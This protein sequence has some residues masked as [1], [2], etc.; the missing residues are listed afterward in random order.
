M[1]HNET[2]LGFEL[3][4]SARNDGTL[5]VAYI[6][7]RV[8]N[9][10]RSREVIEDTLI[11][12]YDA[13]DKLLGVEILAPVKLSDLTKLVEHARRPSFRKFVKT[14]GPPCLVQV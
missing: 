4:L 3:S 2:V 9:I 6:R 1:K 8:G 12:D 5:E 13:H 14:S 10:K 7:F 11:A